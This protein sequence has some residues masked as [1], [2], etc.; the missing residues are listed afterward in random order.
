MNGTAFNPLAE[1]LGMMHIQSLD[2]QKMQ[3]NMTGDAYT[4]KGNID[5]Y[6]KNMKVQLLKKDEDNNTL[7]S[8][9]VISFFTNM[10]LPNDNP[11]KNGKF[12]KGP[13]NIVRAPQESFFGFIWRGMLD[14]LSSAMSGM[15]QKKAEPGNK[16]IEMGTIF[17]G[18]KQG[19]EEKSAVGDKQR[20]NDLKKA[21][22][23]KRQ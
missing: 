4:A 7:K 6:Y 5:Y 2:I 13:I 20:L 14:G 11:K 17:A 9:H 19:P 21:K 18:P 1:P 12:R 10:V 22:K 23:Q 3:M 16:A 8:R 15:D